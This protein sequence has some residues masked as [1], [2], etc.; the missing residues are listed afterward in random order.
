MLRPKSALDNETRMG[1]AP[2][3]CIQGEVEFAICPDYQAPSAIQI[4][5]APVL[6]IGIRPSHYT[7]FRNN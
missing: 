7:Q 4:R 3:D 1:F 6:F 2:V 5:T